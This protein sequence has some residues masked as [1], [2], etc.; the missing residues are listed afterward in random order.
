MHAHTFKMNNH[1]YYKFVFP[2]HLIWKWLGINSKESGTNREFAFTT[3]EDVFIRAK[4]YAHP[5]LLCQELIQR[6]PV[7]IDIGGEYKTTHVSESY[8]TKTIDTKLCVSRDLV[9]DVDSNDYPSLETPGGCWCKFSVCSRCWVRMEAAIKVLYRALKEDFGFEKI[10]FFFSGRR[11]IH[12]WVRDERARVLENDGRKALSDYMSLKEFDSI[13][14]LKMADQ[15]LDHYKFIRD[16]ELVEPLFSRFCANQNLFMGSKGY[17]ELVHLLL[18][19]EYDKKQMVNLL[20]KDQTKIQ[21]DVPAWSVFKRNV[22]RVLATSKYK[23]K[24]LSRCL[25]A[26]VFHYLYPRLDAG[27]TESKAHLIRLPFSV[28]DKSGRIC[29]PLQYDDEDEK[30]NKWIET[31]DPSMVPTVD[32]I[33]E[34]INNLE[35]EQQ[36]VTT[37][38]VTSTR[39]SRSRRP[40]T[41]IWKQTSL[42]PYITYFGTRI[43]SKVTKVES[44]EW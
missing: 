15:Y 31:F 27:V 18:Y 2:G 17:L 20:V 44:S 16:Y 22:H 40:L 34:E 8:Q 38:S 43:E 3:S 42:E 1:V 14:K 9:F 7:K 37:D 39:P 36:H 26:C 10:D 33:L 35:R 24:D 41:S 28:H 4:F 21:D 23:S 13:V 30:E 12:C 6:S 19:K 5:A 29:V 25:Q 11:G 32:S